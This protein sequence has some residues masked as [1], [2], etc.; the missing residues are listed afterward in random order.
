MRGE[1]RNSNRGFTLI[2]AV[3]S[4]LILSVV[5][6]S[7]I[8]GFN[9]ITN[10]NYKAKKIQGANTLYSDI[11]E[12]L[13]DASNYSEAQYI[14]D[15]E[16]NGKE[17]SVGAL[18][19]T[20]EASI[21]PAG[22]EEYSSGT[23]AVLT[24][25]V[26]VGTFTYV[27]YRGSSDEIEY[28][29]SPSLDKYYFNGYKLSY[30][31]FYGY[32]IV[33]DSNPHYF[34]KENY[35]TFNYYYTD[36]EGNKMR[37][38]LPD[39]APTP[40]TDPNKAIIVKSY[41]N[42][43][44]QLNSEDYAKFPVFDSTVKSFL[45]DYSVYDEVENVYEADDIALI[46]KQDAVQGWSSKIAA[47]FNPQVGDKG[48]VVG[49]FVYYKF[50]KIWESDPTT[51]QTEVKYVIATMLTYNKGVY[52]Y[53]SDNFYGHDYIGDSCYVNGVKYS[54]LNMGW[55]KKFYNK[56]G[57][58]VTNKYTVAGSLGGMTGRYDK[59]GIM[60]QKWLPNHPDNTNIPMYYANEYIYYG[61]AGTV[62]VETINN[63]LPEYVIASG[64]ADGWDSEYGPTSST[65][66]AELAAINSIY[67]FYTPYIEP[68]ADG[69]PGTM[70]ATDEKFLNLGL[71]QDA[72]WDYD[73]QK[74]IY[75][76]VSGK[77][78]TP[79]DMS[80][81]GNGYMIKYWR[82]AD[83]TEAQK[84]KM[85][86]GEKKTLTNALVWSKEG[87]A[88]SGE[89]YSRYTGV[90]YA[91]DNKYN[92]EF[93]IVSEDSVLDDGLP[94]KAAKVKVKLKFGTDQILEKEWYLYFK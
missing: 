69:T 46:H 34:T 53:V 81:T 37:V 22:G 36:V 13:R 91:A 33:P 14:I 52:Q 20:V 90:N 70:K 19:Y 39:A 78:A 25:N 66:E 48:R 74:N 77:D 56:F 83:Y 44:H 38:K 43:V 65:A 21:D 86:F 89:A 11:N 1:N 51:R 17:F 59:D 5:I 18:K 7:I 62:K 80:G 47:V 28:Y 8:G 88:S 75:F 45:M 31:Y 40:T 58:G 42:Y 23:P 30:S 64:V 72:S 16:L 55:Y 10:A 68:N 49:K 67:L 4:M 24:D 27:Y 73:K 32:N 94:D 84:E 63:S 93:S 82:W 54:T 60:N 57:I 9:I 71:Y 35:G 29:Y 50:K 61:D 92:S 3:V 41:D 2:E 6:L 85:F 87:T 79:L 76:L 26:K 12:T 15:N